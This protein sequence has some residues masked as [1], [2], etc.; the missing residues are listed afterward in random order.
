MS[1]EITFEHL[2]ILFSV[3]SIVGAIL[4]ARKNKWGF[5]VWICGNFGWIAA[6]IIYEMYAQI[7]VWV[8][9]TLTATYGFR[10]WS[11]EEK[12]GVGDMI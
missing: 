11:R 9:F 2:T 8:V 7:P 12:D 10:R 6:D 5:I 4:N 3:I 1:F